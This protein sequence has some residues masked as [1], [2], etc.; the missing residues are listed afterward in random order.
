[1]APVHTTDGPT[2]LVADGALDLTDKRQQ[3]SEPPMPWSTRVPATRSAAQAALAQ[4]A[5]PT[6]APLTEGYRDQAFT[7]TDGEVVPRGMLIDSEARHPPAPH[8]VDTP[9]SPQ[10]AKAAR[11]V[12]P[13]CCT[14]LACETEAQP[15]LST[16]QHG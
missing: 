10:R 9:L 4:A 5:P 16:C 14:A 11:A 13:L 12:Q 6:M 2:S 7:S 1:M 15:A 3:L 8:P